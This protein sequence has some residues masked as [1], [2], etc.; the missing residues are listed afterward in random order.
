MASRLIPAAW[1]IWSDGRLMGEANITGM[2]RLMRKTSFRQP[3]ETTRARFA[4]LRGVVEAGIKHRK[5]Q[6]CPTT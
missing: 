2:R 4:R 1:F 3:G 6:A 5:G